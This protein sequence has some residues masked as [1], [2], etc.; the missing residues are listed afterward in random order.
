MLSIR[1]YCVSLD[2]TETLEADNTFLE[3][4]MRWSTH[5]LMTAVYA[6]EN[7]LRSLRD[8]PATAEVSLLLSKDE[9]P[10]SL[11]GSYRELAHQ[12]KMRPGQICFLSKNP[13]E[14]DR[15]SKV[16]YRTLLVLKPGAE[17][18]AGFDQRR[19]VVDYSK[20]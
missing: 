10:S 2:S 19:I 18:P 12:L 4:L 20:L 8:S 11:A 14:I 15:A 13:Q 16:G 1:A 6:P 17:V 9:W 5:G 3:A 7:L